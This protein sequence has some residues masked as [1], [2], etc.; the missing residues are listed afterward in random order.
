M[1]MNLQDKS[2]TLE[3]Q[4]A[5]SNIRLFGTSSQVFTADDPQDDEE[6]PIP[7]TMVEGF[8]SENNNDS[9]DDADDYDFENGEE[10][11]NITTNVIQ[12]N[13]GHFNH[14]SLEVSQHIHERMHRHRIEYA[15]SD[16]DFGDDE[17]F[18]YPNA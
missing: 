18:T 4:V 11:E 2:A 3:Y 6:D 15:E 7:V 9:E 17:E 14:P 8:S 13:T 16:S 10:E 5:Q 12:R 1:V